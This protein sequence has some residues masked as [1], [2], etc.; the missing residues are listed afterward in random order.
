MNMYKELKSDLGLDIASHG[1]LSSWAQQGVLMLNT[2]LTVRAH[3]P[4]S[5]S[6]I[7]WET[8]TDAVIRKISTQKKNVV[9]ILWGGFARKKKSLIDEDK[10][11][12]IESA[13]PSPLSAYNGFFN[14][15]PYSKVNE[16]LRAN[17]LGE[18]NWQITE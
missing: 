14:S 8:F 5:H 15:K 13:H 6:K 9:F 12:I 1:C 4:M 7:G 17:N 10:H 2:S 11:H 16:Y 18:I 3:E